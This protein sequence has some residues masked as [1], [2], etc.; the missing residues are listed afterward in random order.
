MKEIILI[1]ANPN[2]Q[3]NQNSLLG[4]TFSSIIAV[5]HPKVIEYL[6]SNI[7]STC[8]SKSSISILFP[9]TFIISSLTI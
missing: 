1:S 5:S 8:F 3:K 6:P 7:S 2:S 4:V 9:F